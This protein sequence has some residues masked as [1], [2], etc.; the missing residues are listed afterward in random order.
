MA[1][2]FHC[3]ARIQGP[4]ANQRGGMT[5]NVFPPSGLREEK[6]HSEH[7]VSKA[8]EGALNLCTVH[9]L[10]SGSGPMALRRKLTL[11]SKHLATQLGVCHLPGFHLGSNIHP[12]SEK[13]SIK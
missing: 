7:E 1:K 3:Q 12:P 8:G 9:R 13:S 5:G 11:T 4:H 10:S 2:V 6:L